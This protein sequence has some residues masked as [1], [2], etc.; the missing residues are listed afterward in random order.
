[1]RPQFITFDIFGTVV[2]WRAG[3]ELAC[4]AADRPLVPGEFD[5][6]VDA[7]GRLQKGEF[8]PYTEVTVRSLTEVLSVSVAVASRITESI[9]TWPFYSE[10]ANALAELIEIVPCAAMTNSDHVHGEQIQER[11]GFRLAEW[12]CAE[13][14]GVYKPDVRFFQAMAARRDTVLGKDWWHVSAYADYDLAQANHLG[15]STVFVN[16]PHSRPGAA[17]YRVEDLRELIRLVHNA[18]RGAS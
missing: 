15:L 7:Q 10:S 9:G 17:T 13:E 2:D 1:M 4:K 5:R 11:L 8:L 3:L 18:T 12:L 6:L 14:T 16:R